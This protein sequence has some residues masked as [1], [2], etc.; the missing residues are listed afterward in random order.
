MFPW[1][2]RRNFDEQNYRNKRKFPCHWQPPG[3]RSG[4]PKRNYKKDMECLA[5]TIHFLYRKTDG[6]R[7][8]RH[9]E[10]HYGDLFQWAQ[11]MVKIPAT[12]QYLRLGYHYQSLKSDD[13]DI[14][15]N[16]KIFVNRFKPSMTKF[17]ILILEKAKS[18]RRNVWIYGIWCLKTG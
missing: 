3:W 10:P 5:Y 1:Y 4:L 8:L 13:I 11:W 7:Q 12:I 17:V 15:F 16:T 6:L 18:M 14:D 2:G 9:P